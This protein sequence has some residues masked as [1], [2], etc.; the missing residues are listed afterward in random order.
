[1]LTRIGVCCLV[2]SLTGFAAARLDDPTSDSRAASADLEAKLLHL[3]ESASRHPDGELSA[4]V[5]AEVLP[6]LVEYDSEGRPRTVR[7]RQLNTLL[8]EELRRLAAR[9]ADLEAA[10]ATGHPARRPEPLVRI[11]VARHE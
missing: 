6:D 9:V 5:V 2:L 7:H 8:L 11:T 1:M 4:P 3:Q 10:T